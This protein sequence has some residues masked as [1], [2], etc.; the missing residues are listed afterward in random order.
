MQE[1]L[2][3][4]IFGN[5][6][7]SYLTSLG[8]FIG[9]I[10]IVFIFK[11]YILSR[12]NR[13]AESTSTTLDDLLVRA[14]E[15]SLIPVFYFG[16]FYLSLHTLILSPD[17]KKGLSIAAIILITILI[18]RTVISAVNHVLVS[19]FKKSD[20]AAE[21]E[22]QLKGIRGLV[23]LVIWA[24][25]LIFLLDNL[26]VKISAVVAGL[27]IGGIAVALAA[28]AVLG[29]LFS[30]FVIFFDKPFKIGDFIIVGDKVGVVEYTGIKTTRIRALSGEQIVFSNTDLTNSRVHNYK[31]MER[32]RV[33]FKLGVTYQ[34]SAKQLKMIPQIVKQII[35]EQKDA[36]FDRGHFASY[37]DFSLNFEFVYYVTGSDYNKY[38][39]IQQTI[40]LTI[41]ETFEK[42][43]IEFAY[44]SQ[45]L[46][47]N[48]VNTEN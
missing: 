29:D 36:T 38:M 2:N 8:I 14:I 37:G 24:I 13:W 9:G 27:G 48:K 34:T 7:L 42:E 25:A 11:K 3:Y 19:Y 16:I 40:N 47:V 30:Y 6:V 39:D 10:V 12:L 28:Q 15:K 33:V 31:K 32:R 41:F 21:N 22:K 45:T 5:T 20:D 46:F 43:G 18:V 1:I 35:E 4:S 23:N 17:F 44:P 26:G